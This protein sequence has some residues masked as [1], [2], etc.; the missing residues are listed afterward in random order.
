MIQQTALITGASSGIGEALAYELANRGYN[1]VL[2]ARRKQQL[3]FVQQKVMQ[4]GRQ[5][6]LIIADLTDD[7]QLEAL[8][9]QISQIQVHLLILNAGMG[10]S[11]S[12]MERDSE[13]E[14]QMTKL[15]IDANIK[16][17]RA[18]LPQML[19]RQNGGILFVSSVLA[20]Y[21]SPYM[22]TYAAT[23]AFIQSYGES[24][25]IELAPAG[26][27]VSILCPGSTSSE[28]AM[29]SGFTQ[30]QAMSATKVAQIAIKHHLHGKRVIIPGY[31]NRAL[32]RLTHLMPKKLL[33]PLMEKLFRPRK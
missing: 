30:K 3:E 2:I 31:H 14:A 9:T 18:M 13:T 24:L 10:Q 20:F 33:D 16:L 26:I 29:Q 11:G 5:A 32:A 22:T 23:K 4:I 8:T 15:N 6:T 25:A 7:G 1:L 21:P 17:T 27:Q 28:F 12:Y 19:N